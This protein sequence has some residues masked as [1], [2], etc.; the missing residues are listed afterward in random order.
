MILA[1]T[2][3]AAGAGGNFRIMDLFAMSYE[4]HLNTKDYFNFRDLFALQGKSFQ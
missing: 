2:R 4:R 3:D 1:Y